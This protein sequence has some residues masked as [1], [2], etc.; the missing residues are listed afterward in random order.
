MNDM[1]DARRLKRLFQGILVAS[2]VPGCGGIDRDQFTTNACEGTTEFDGVTPATPVDFMELRQTDPF[3]DPPVANPIATQGTACSKAT[4]MTCI[5]T[6]N[7]LM[8]SGGWSISRG[9]LGI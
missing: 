7:A 9:E 8:V 5:N 2:F 4:S 6:F 3:S 1:M